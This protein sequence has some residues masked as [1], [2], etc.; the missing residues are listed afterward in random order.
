MPNKTG[1]VFCGLLGIIKTKRA[2]KALCFDEFYFLL[3]RCVD[4]TGCG[5]AFKI[6]ITGFG[7][8]V[9]LFTFFLL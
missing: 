7:L 2:L 5:N 3:F 8:A 9:F 6:V 4:F 1:V